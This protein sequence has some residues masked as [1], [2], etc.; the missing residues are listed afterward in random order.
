MDFVTSM[1][2]KN[3]DNTNEQYKKGC[4]DTEKKYQKIARENEILK[5]QIRKLGYEIGEKPN[6]IIN[7]VAIKKECRSRTSCEG[8][9][10]NSSSGC[11]LSGSNPSEWKI[12]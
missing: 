12:M 9:E 4:D 7:A 1:F 8:C 11:V 6:Q 5:A 10:L 2:K 3:N